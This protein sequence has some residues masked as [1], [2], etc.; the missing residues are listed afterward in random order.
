MKDMLR[1]S[2][3][4]LPKNPRR[5][6]LR[7]YCMVTAEEWRPVRPAKEDSLLHPAANDLELRTAQEITCKSGFAWQSDGM[8][9]NQAAEQLQ[10]IR[11]LMERSAIYR[12]ALAPIM[13]FCGVV[14]MAGGGLGSLLAIHSTREFILF[15]TA[16]ALGALTGSFLLVRRQALKQSEAFW[17][18]PTRRVAQALTPAFSLGAVCSV[19]A[20]Y[21]WPTM[22]A[23]W[24][25]VPVWCILYGL[26]V[27][28]AGFFMPRG[29]KLFGWIF[30]IIGCWLFHRWICVSF[31][32]SNPT[33]H[34]LM[35]GIFGG[36]HLAYG[37]YLYFTEKRGKAS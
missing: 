15:W 4:A 21:Y 6:H 29:L 7:F 32:F 17:S 12:R 22:D 2:L 20:W 19:M 34:W 5:N 35:G 31:L 16:M 18:P 13:I 36:L 30:I 3:L 14:G 9:L 23:N 25:L 24:G 10:T 37:I 8:E 27:H 26:G 33:P 11:T 28:A 1:T